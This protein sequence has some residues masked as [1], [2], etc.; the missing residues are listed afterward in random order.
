MCKS[1]TG[2]SIPTT[3]VLL[4]WVKVTSTVMT[5]ILS[6]GTVPRDNSTSIIAPPLVVVSVS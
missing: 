3:V 2:T 6:G 4:S 5:E 1:V